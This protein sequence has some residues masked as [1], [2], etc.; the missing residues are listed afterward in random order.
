MTKMHADQVDIDED[1]VRGLV[2]EQFPQWADLPLRRVDSAGTVNA[3]YRLGGDMV[4]RLPLNRS[5]LG[6]VDREEYWLPKLAPL[7]PLT[8]PTPL[9]RGGPGDGYPFLWS[10]HRWLPGRSADQ[11]D[12]ESP[13]EAA[14][15]LARF[16]TRLWRIDPTQGPHLAGSTPLAAMDDGV[17][18]AI[19][20]L[21]G[22]IDTGAA[23]LAWEAALRAPA[24][25][26]PP[27]LVHRDLLPGNLLAVDGRLHAVIDFGTLGAGD[28]AT[29]ML[30]AWSLFSGEAREV[31]R[32]CL[33][34]D[35]ATWARGKGYALAKGLVGLPYYQDTNPRFAALARRLIDAVLADTG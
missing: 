32:E 19:R 4:L 13:G 31:F 18:A 16:A 2:D 24:W 9:A 29:D 11:A 20:A 28:P 34:V 3:I 1:L 14:A 7:L 26:G 27:L 21:E 23:S 25:D 30:P 12:L 35:A 22:R 5:G 6:D 15:V 8:I 10:V 33:D 17:R